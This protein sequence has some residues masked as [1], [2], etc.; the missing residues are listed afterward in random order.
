M[1]PA[2]TIALAAALGVA[3]AACTASAPIRPGAGDPRAARALLKEAA[4]DGA[5]RLETNIPTTG[6]LGTLTREE[7]ERLAARGVTGLDVR[8]GMPPEATGPARLLLIFDPPPGFEPTRAC[9]AETLPPAVP[10]GSATRL[11][12]VFC[13][14]GAFVADTVGTT[15]GDAAELERLV[16]RSTTRLFPDD[17]AETYGF[18]LFGYRL[19]L[20]GTLGF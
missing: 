15:T 18:N 12:A 16:W 17:Y 3:L 11:R 8:F 10:T 5:V 14:G 6:A 19:G 2:P 9:A 13:N 1:K 7:I 20:H 4:A